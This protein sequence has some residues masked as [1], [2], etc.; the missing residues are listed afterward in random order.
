MKYIVAISKEMIYEMHIR[1]DNEDEAIELA[2][3]L[4]TENQDSFIP[5]QTEIEAFDI[6]EIKE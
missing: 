2:E 1:A 6:E 5:V 3:K 4:F